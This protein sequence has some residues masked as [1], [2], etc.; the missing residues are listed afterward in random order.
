MTISTPKPPPEDQAQSVPSDPV[1]TGTKVT[2]SASNPKEQDGF[3]PDPIPQTVEKEPK[4][5]SDPV[6]QPP[7]P[8]IEDLYNTTSSQEK[9]CI[10]EQDAPL[11]LDKQTV[12]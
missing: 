8:V 5:D 1:V 2:S 12:L 7:A 11:D 9:A 4:P 3:G 6:V 10:E